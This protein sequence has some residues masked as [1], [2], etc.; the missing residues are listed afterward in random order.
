MS[1]ILPAIAHFRVLGYWLVLLVSFLESLAFVGVVV[2]GAAFVVLAGSLA[3]RGY[4]DLGDLV[5]FAS[6]GAVLGDGISFRLGRGGH[7]RFREGNRLF[8][9]S[10]LEK[11]EAFFD[12]HGGKSVFL[13]RFVG[14]VR[15]VVPFVAGVYGMEAKRFYLWNVASAILWASA[16][17][18]AGYYLGQAWRTVE[19]WSTRLGVAVAAALL[20]LLAAWWLKRFLEKRGRELAALAASLLGSAGAAVVRSPIVRRVQENH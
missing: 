5:W 14:L 11:G 9:P 19:T 2:P 18:L 4:L 16:H 12:R 3:S 7:I 1:A 10:L 15:A 8:K 6:A 20:L 17:L 13:G